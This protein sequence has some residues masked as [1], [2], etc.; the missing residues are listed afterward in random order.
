MIVNYVRDCSGLRI[1][2]LM[3]N[4]N[5]MHQRLNTEHTL[6]TKG[7]LLDDLNDLKLNLARSVQRLDKGFSQI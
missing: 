1:V 5:I 6:Q 4:Y 3:Q 2:I 7:N